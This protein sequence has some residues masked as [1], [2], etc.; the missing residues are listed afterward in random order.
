M[1]MVTA[2]LARQDRQR[3]SLK[4]FGTRKTAPRSRDSGFDHGS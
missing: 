1:V 4:P 2:C 3:A